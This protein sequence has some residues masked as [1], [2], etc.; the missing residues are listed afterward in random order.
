MSIRS[1]TACLAA[2]VIAV[3]LLTHA[4][5]EDARLPNS[6]AYPKTG[7]VPIPKV[8]DS[9]AVDLKL[10]YLT[11]AESMLGQFG[12][13][14]PA[15]AKKLACIGPDM[16]SPIRLDKSQLLSLL[17]SAQEDM[18]SDIRPTPRLRLLSGQTTDIFLRDKI[19]PHFG[20]EFRA[21]GQVLNPKPDF[22]ETGLQIVARAKASEDRKQVALDLKIKQTELDREGVMVP[23]TTQLKLP[24]EDGKGEKT[25]HYTCLFNQPRARTFIDLDRSYTLNQGETVILGAWKKTK[26]VRVTDCGPPILRDIPIVNW[27]FE[28]ERYQPE[29]YVVLF[30]ITSRVVVNGGQR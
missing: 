1:Q 9:G 14:D 21:N 29:S 22:V 27:L 6:P 4:I 15:L 30:M 11:V 18:R 16:K 26:Q 28:D 24:S 25:V 3:A 8:D 10:S 19:E 23:V 17:R 12:A 13:A 7:K 5:A 20:V 2:T